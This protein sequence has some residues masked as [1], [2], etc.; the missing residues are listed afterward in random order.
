M[1]AEDPRVAQRQK[2]IDAVR[3]DYRGVIASPALSRL[4]RDRLQHAVDLWNDAENRLRRGSSCAPPALMTPAAERASW[5]VYHEYTMDLCAY[6]LACGVTPVISYALLH[7]GDDAPDLFDEQFELHSEAHGGSVGGLMGAGFQWRLDRMAHFGNRLLELTDATGAPLLDSTM[8]IWGHE[9]TF[10]GAHPNSGHWDLMLGTACGRISG[11][12]YLDVMGEPRYDGDGFYGTYVDC[13]PYNRLLLTTLL[14]VG[15]TNESIEA[16]TGSAG[17]G[18]YGEVAL[19]T[20][21]H[22]RGASFGW[23]NDN[24]AR[25]YT[26]AEKRK[27]LPIL[28]TP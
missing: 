2:L 5:R 28:R 26:D 9:Y 20:N 12:N 11:G 23:S 16:I 24:R 10:P 4:D 8:L 18:E 22:R 14:A 21:D 13:V 7:T 19:G 3:E 15:H 25:F 1:G 27:P 6:A 17:F